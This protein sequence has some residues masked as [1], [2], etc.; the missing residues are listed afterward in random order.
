VNRSSLIQLPTGVRRADSGRRLEDHPG[1]QHDGRA[2]DLNR[3]IL[4]GQIIAI[5]ALLF[6]RSIVKAL[7]KAKR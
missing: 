6:T 7:A 1:R 3:T 5:V 4:V 2:F